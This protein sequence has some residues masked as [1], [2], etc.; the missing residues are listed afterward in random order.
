M[1]S[2]TDIHYITGFLYIVSRQREISVVLGE[3]VYDEAA[4]SERDVDIVIASAGETEMIGIEVKDKGR[5]L[6]VSIV[7]GICSK[8]HDMPTITSKSIVSSSG[9][10]KPARRKATKYGVQCLTIRRGSVPSFPSIDLSHLHEIT[11]IGKT[12]LDGPHFHFM[13]QTK[14]PQAIRDQL[15]PDTPISY[16]PD[17]PK[18]DITNLQGLMSNLGT[19]LLNDWDGPV[20]TGDLPVTFDVHI[21]DKPHLHIGDE[22]IEITHARVAGTIR[23]SPTTVPIGDSCYLENDL[24]EPFAASILVEFNGAL[25]GFSASVHN[26][27]L[28]MFNIPQLVRN[29][30]PIR[31]IISTN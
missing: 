9:Y 29:I 30:R 15:N 3:K 27:E 6:D 14:I 26:Q 24:G 18:A 21:D 28:R 16:P 20:E 12:W 1:L 25:L 19:I 8:F 10:T 23:F 17:A 13:P 22:I 4:E 7:E 5:P 31:K 11:F 2:E